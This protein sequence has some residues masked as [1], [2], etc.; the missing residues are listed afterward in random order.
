[1][2]SQSARYFIPDPS[3]YP[4]FGS[5]ALLGM[6]LTASGGNLILI[7]VGIEITGL[8]ASALS[9]SLKPSGPKNL[10]PLSW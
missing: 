5:A 3:R 10:M 8:S 2:M 7:F 1:M 6:M 4:I 9:A